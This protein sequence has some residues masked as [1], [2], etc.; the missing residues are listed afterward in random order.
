MKIIMLERKT[1]DRNLIDCI[2][3]LVFKTG[4]G[5]DDEMDVNR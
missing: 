3:I 2:T 5:K 4:Q 1:C